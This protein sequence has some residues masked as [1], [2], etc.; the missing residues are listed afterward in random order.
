MNARLERIGA[1]MERIDAHACR[2]ERGEPGRLQAMLG[3]FFR[4]PCARGRCI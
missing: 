3:G 2:M 1:H 4:L